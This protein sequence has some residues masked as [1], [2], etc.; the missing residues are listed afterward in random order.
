M[1]E[2]IVEKS[3]LAEHVWEN[4]HLIKWDETMVTD[5]ARSS[6]ELLLKE[7]IHSWLSQLPINRNG[8][9]ELP[10]RWMAEGTANQKQSA[11]L[12]DALG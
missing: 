11:T 5:Q 10:A 3:A 1:S 7:V 12:I 4:H 6:K 2:G 9:L 8:G